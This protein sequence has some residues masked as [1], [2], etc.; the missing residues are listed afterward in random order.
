MS[1]LPLRHL[2]GF[3]D[4]IT[5]S[6]SLAIYCKRLVMD[7]KTFSVVPKAIAAML[8]GVMALMSGMVLIYALI[9]WGGKR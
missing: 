6:S 2:I 1:Q 3:S 7:A 9:V 4:A 8:F 5:G